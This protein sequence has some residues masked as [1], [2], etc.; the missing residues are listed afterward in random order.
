MSTTV[1]LSPGTAVLFSPPVATLL[2]GGGGPPVV[3]EPA[4][5]AL[6]IEKLLPATD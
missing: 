5:Q 4:R 1:G 2:P 6:P 3:D